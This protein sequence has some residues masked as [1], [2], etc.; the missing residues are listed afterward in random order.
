MA[1]IVSCAHPWRVSKTGT[2]HTRDEKVAPS[3][4]SQI[5][6]GMAHETVNVSE[7]AQ[8][9]LSSFREVLVFDDS[10]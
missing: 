2:L 1:L 4:R 9:R 10:L 8:R 6:F 3:A 5:G 7:P